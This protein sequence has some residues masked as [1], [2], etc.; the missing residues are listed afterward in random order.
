MNYW[1]LSCNPARWEIDRAIREKIVDDHWLVGP[2]DVRSIQF[3]DWALVRVGTDKRSSAQ[4]N[5]TPRLE[6]GIYGVCSIESNPTP[7]AGADS[8]YW[9]ANAESEPDPPNR[10]HVKIKW[11]HYFLDNPLLLSSLDV[12]PPV[13]SEPE[14]IIKAS[15]LYQS[16][17]RISSADFNLIRERLSVPR[18]LVDRI[19]PEVRT[20]DHL[21]DADLSD[22][23]YESMVRRI[24]DG[25]IGEKVKMANDFKC[26]IC[27][28]LGTPQISFLKPG[29]QR[30][31]EAHHAIPKHKLVKGSLHRSNVISVCANHHRQLHFGYSELGGV[32]HEGIDQFLRRSDSGK[33]LIFALDGREI[34]VNSN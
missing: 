30:Y 31:A 9:L 18:E 16:T 26:Q 24:E 23:Q 14:R 34:I 17:G 7:G 22:H 28:A 11:H 32:R 8:K 12:S 10:H 6:P 4:L 20:D 19:D 25:G 21:L 29:G 2:Q 27:G 3:G 33:H 15:G 1:I 13:L 5:G